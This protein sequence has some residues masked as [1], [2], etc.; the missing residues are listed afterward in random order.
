MPGN[1]KPPTTLLLSRFRVSDLVFLGSLSGRSMR[2]S[3]GQIKPPD[4]GI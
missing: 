4:V 1:D 2:L 3:L